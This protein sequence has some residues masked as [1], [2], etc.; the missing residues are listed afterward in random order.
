MSDLCVQLQFC[1]EKNECKFILNSWYFKY[2]I[3]FLDMVLDQ[4]ASWPIENKKDFVQDT[5][6]DVSI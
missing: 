5:F 6:S 4:Y 3:L 1:R 2:C